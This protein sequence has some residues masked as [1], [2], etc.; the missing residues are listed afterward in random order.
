M[1]ELLTTWRFQ[2]NK[3][4]GNRHSG[5]RVRVAVSRDDTP[6]DGKQKQALQR[7]DDKAREDK[8]AQNRR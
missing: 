7:P 4:T 5:Y 2:G 3:R 1:D 6:N 8:Q